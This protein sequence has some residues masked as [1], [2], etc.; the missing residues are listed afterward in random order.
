MEKI[1]AKFLLDENI[2][3]KVKR[4]II[5]LGFPEVY[6]LQE[7]GFQGLKNGQLST[8]VK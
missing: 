3:K 5:E 8:I 4:L 1:N 7:L 6:T 2:P